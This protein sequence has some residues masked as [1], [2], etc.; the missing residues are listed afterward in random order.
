MALA[1]AFR[2]ATRVEDDPAQ[3]LGDDPAQLLGAILES[4]GRAR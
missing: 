2:P 3:P 4:L 1:I